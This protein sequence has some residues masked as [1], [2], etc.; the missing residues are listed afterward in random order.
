MYVFQTNAGTTSRA[1]CFGIISAPAE[2]EQMLDSLLSNEFA[3]LGEA[4]EPKDTIA[5]QL[6]LDI[7]R[8]DLFR[9]VL[10]SQIGCLYIDLGCNL[11]ALQ[12]RLRQCLKAHSVPENLYIG[13][14][15]SSK[16]SSWNNKLDEKLDLHPE[17]KFIVVNDGQKALSRVN[18]N[19]LIGSSLMIARQKKV[20]VLLIDQQ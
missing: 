7:S 3:R 18:Y 15:V 8:G 11:S 10:D 13:T 2:K 16:E 20:S 12:G 4:Q 19:K 14:N 5:L 17:I 9:N 6:S 1:Q